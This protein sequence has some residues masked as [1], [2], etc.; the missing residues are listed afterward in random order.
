MSRPSAANSQSPADPGNISCSRKVQTDSECL[1]PSQAAVSIDRLTSSLMYRVSCKRSWC[2]ETTRSLFFCVIKDTSTTTSHT[3]K[4]D[5][6]MTLTSRAQ[7]WSWC[8]HQYLTETLHKD[9][10]G[11]SVAS[12]KYLIVQKGAR[13][14]IPTTECEGTCTTAVSGSCWSVCEEE[15]IYML[16]FSATT[17]SESGSRPTCP[18]SS[19]Y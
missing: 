14:S 19:S 5:S 18:G 3:P 7:Y 2:H 15:M 1:T 13:R 11:G 4:D 9:E 8:Q 12:D 10:G 6:S 17:A 16:H